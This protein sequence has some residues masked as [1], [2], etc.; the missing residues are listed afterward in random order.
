MAKINVKGTEII[1]SIKEKE[2]ISL[3]DTVRH[4]ENVKY[5]FPDIK[6]LI[7]LYNNNRPFS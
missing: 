3:T 2:Y 1:I 7:P 6:K 5:Q 4:I